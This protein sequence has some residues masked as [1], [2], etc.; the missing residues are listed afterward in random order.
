MPLGTLS[1]RPDYVL[2]MDQQFDVFVWFGRD[3]PAEAEERRRAVQFAHAL[4]EDG[5]FPRP[6]LSVFEEK[7]SFAR[8]LRAR[9]S[10]EH[11]DDPASQLATNPLLQE[12]S[13]D[14]IA[15]FRLRLWSDYSD[16]ECFQQWL[17]RVVGGG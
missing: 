4:A 17:G 15:K 5:R 9:L 2:V 14:Q 13:A 8:L 6:S 12:L 1:L 16:E 7:E 10:P 11:K 3:V